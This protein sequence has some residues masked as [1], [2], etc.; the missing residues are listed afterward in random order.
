MQT[1]I[2]VFLVLF[3]CC[4]LGIALYY[5]II[6]SKE[7]WPW[8][9][10][11]PNYNLGEF[12]YDFVISAYRENL[13]WIKHVKGKPTLFIY[14]KHEETSNQWP[15]NTISLPNLG[16]C[17]QTYLYHIIKHYEHLAPVTL[18]ATGSTNSLYHKRMLLNHI[19]FPRLAKKYKCLGRT[20]PTDPKFQL[21]DW[22]ATAK[23]NQI[24]NNNQIIKAN[25][26]PF[27]KWFAYNFP[28]LSFPRHMVIYG[29]FAATREAIQNVPLTVWKQLLVQHEVGDNVEVGHFMERSWFALLTQNY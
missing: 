29:V 6:Y 18:F 19:I 23:E 3:F 16:R 9:S 22:K 14:S 1:Q 2:V 24:D 10:I 15:N 12:K 17:D 4:L 28:T 7:S 5:I 20:T 8:L 11:W 13:D 26:R 21:D 25:F 27:S